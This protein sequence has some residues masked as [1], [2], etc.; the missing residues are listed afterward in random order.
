VILLSGID[1]PYWD[2][3]NL[4][5][6]FPKLADM[7]SVFPSAQIYN[8]ILTGWPTLKDQIGPHLFAP[9]DLKRKIETLYGSYLVALKN[10]ATP[11]QLADRNPKYATASFMT[12]QTGIRRDV[13]IAFLTTLEKLAKAGTIDQ[14]YWAPDRVAA[15]NVQ[16][17][18]RQKQADATRPQGPID[19]FLSTAR[20]FG[21]GLMLLGGLGLAAYLVPYF[22]RRK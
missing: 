5:I 21:G 16:V 8:A 14:R 12:Q 11:Y 15:E 22:K 2:T 6:L 10:G 7:L 17:T 3:F 19:N 1:F 13:V 9:A 4:R 20:T 18:A